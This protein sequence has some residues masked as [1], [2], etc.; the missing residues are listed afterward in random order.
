MSENPEKFQDYSE[1]E[2]QRV[3]QFFTILIEID[4]DRN[5]VKRELEKENLKPNS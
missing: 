3:R 1:E 2:L 4:Q 5:K